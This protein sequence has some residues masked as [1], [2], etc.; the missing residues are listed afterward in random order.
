ME[1]NADLDANMLRWPHAR[2]G[3][4]VVSSLLALSLAVY[5]VESAFLW[6]T[7]RKIE[8]H[9]GSITAEDAPKLLRHLRGDDDRW[10]GG[11]V[12]PPP[13]QLGQILDHQYAL[14][15]QCAVLFDSDPGDVGLSAVEG[16]R[17]VAEL[18]LPNASISDAGLRSL[19]GLARLRH[20]NLHGCA[21]VTGLGLRHVRGFALLRSVTLAGTALDDEGLTNLDDL[22]GL[23]HLDLSRTRVTGAGLSHLAHFRTL[24]SLDLTGTAIDDRSIRALAGLP[25]TEIKL[26]GTGIT[27]AGLEYLEKLP[28][29]RRID[30]ATTAVSD[31]GLESL[32]RLPKLSSVELCG[33][34]VTVEAGRRLLGAVAHMCT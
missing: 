27:D 14:R 24:R 18:Q 29:L 5:L 7:L 13:S 17:C 9:G 20:L 28:E 22:P 26:G 16:L 3:L 19:R 8:V 31:A 23:E 2:R 32:R 33:T 10:C 12:S 1:S 21:H 34:R 11:G 6:R 4:L 25:L 30:L 15:N